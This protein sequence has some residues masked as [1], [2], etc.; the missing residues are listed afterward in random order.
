MATFDAVFTANT[1]HIVDADG[2][3]AFFRGVGQVLRPGG[4]LCVYGPFRYRGAFTSASNAAFDADLRARD[5]RSGIRD[6][7][8][9]LELAGAQG[10][11]LV[12]DH[13]MP[14]HNQLLHFRRAAVPGARPE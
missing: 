3:A 8:T 7:E 13:S 2:V 1:L 4:T 11:A 10:L 5:P 9:V 6:F 12:A 14:A